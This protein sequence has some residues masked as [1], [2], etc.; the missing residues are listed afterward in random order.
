MNN[1]LVQFEVSSTSQLQKAL[2]AYEQNGA[3]YAEIRVFGPNILTRQFNFPKTAAKDM[4][5]GL[6]MEASELLSAAVSDVELSF[7]VTSQDEQGVHGV[8]SAMPR[9]LLMEH[10]NCFKGH[11]LTPVSLTA[12]AVGAVTDFLKDQPLPGNNFCLVNFLSSNAVNIIIFDNAKP[13]FFREL[14]DLSEGDFKGKIMDTIRYSCSQSV[15]K[16]IDRI[17]FVG[18]IKDK[19]PLIRSLKGLESAPPVQ[20][21]SP[22]GTRLDLTDMNLLSSYVCDLKERKN[23]IS[24]FSII[25]AATVLAAFFLAW[26]FSV[27]YFKRRDAGHQVNM[28]D[29]QKALELQEKIRQL[30]HG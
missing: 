12:S 29:Y 10:L 4:L 23:I 20:P 14:C 21:I 5:A 1:K 28:S 16:R 11:A 25:L 17:F 9:K 7:K 18:D 13:V 15:S 27:G 6:K 24:V 19:D 2:T 26:Q 22:E 3:L 30:D 8:F